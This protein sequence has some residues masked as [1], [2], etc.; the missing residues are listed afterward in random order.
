MPSSPNPNTTATTSHEDTDFVI[1]TRDCEG[2]QQ[3]ILNRQS[4]FV[5][6]LLSLS[7]LET[8]L[9]KFSLVLDSM[10]LLRLLLHK[11]TWDLSLVA[12]KRNVVSDLHRVGNDIRAHS[13][14]SLGNSFQY[15]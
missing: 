7:N 10:L 14:C 5:Q 12:K 6:T 8:H 11:L 15:V 3:I 1:H 9:C 13:S 2:G 4:P